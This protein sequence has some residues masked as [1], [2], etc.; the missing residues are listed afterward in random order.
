M[1][2]Y[3]NNWKKYNLKISKDE[4]KKAPSTIFAKLKNILKKNR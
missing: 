4:M 1:T 2:N 3:T